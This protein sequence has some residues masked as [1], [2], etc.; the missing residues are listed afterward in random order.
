MCFTAFGKH[1]NAEYLQNNK[2]DENKKTPYEQEN[3]LHQ[4]GLKC[5]V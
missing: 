4:K 1:N 3:V 2:A 5:G